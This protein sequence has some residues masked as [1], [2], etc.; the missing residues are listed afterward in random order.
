MQV[1]LYWII[2]CLLFVTNW[3]ANGVEGSP[4]NAVHN[5]VAIHYED[6]TSKDNDGVLNVTISSSATEENATSFEET[7]SSTEYVVSKSP[8][9]ENVTENLLETSSALSEALKPV[10]K[11]ASPI[12]QTMKTSVV[13]DN[14]TDSKKNETK[15]RLHPSRLTTPKLPTTA[16]N[17]SQLEG[18]SDR[19]PHGYVHYPVMDNCLRLDKRRANWF[20][21]HRD[22]WENDEPLWIAGRRAG[23][24]WKWYGRVRGIITQTN[25]NNHTD[26]PNAHSKVDACVQ[27]LP[28]YFD[29]LW[30]DQPCSHY[31][32]FVCER[33]GKDYSHINA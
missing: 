3:S 17:V 29:H 33:P 8:D 16:T 2:S 6:A 14:S 12:N 7:L 1:K 30:D 15:R 11:E 28:G 32:H 13:L 4:I 5:L 20:Q 23:R 24:V 10:V 27:V 26:E 31:L 9:N 21:A 22:Y 25:W 19:C 18:N